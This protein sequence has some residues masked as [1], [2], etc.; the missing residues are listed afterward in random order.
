MDL[1]CK[2]MPLLRD[3][4]QMWCINSRTVNVTQREASYCR[5]LDIFH[6]ILRLA[7]VCLPAPAYLQCLLSRVSEV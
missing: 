4:P 5:R 1:N 3:S 2:S 6:H 7:P